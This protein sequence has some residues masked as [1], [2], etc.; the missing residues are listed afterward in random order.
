[1]DELLA[2]LERIEAKLNALITALAEDGIEPP[3]VDLDGN[4]L[5]QERE[6]GQPL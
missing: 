3:I 6:P 2:R 5:G 1:M 4:V